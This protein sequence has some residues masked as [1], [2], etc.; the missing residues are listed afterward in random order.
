MAESFADIYKHASGLSRLI[1]KE[2]DNLVKILA[3]IE[4][5]NVIEYE[6]RQTIEG[7]ESLN[8]LDEFFSIKVQNLAIFLPS[9]LPLYSCVVFGIIP[10]FLADK[11]WI[12]PPVKLR[13]IFEKLEKLL[14]LDTFLNLSLFYDSRSAFIKNYASSAD[15]IVF[16]GSYENSLN[17]RKSCAQ[18]C[19]FIF[20]G[21]GHNPILVLENSN[22]DLAV[23]KIFN[24]KM[25]NNGQ[26]CAGPDQI[27]I[28]NS[29]LTLFLEKLIA[30]LNNLNSNCKLAV[31]DNLDRILSILVKYKSKIVY[32]GNV[33]IR[34]NTVQPSIIISSD[35]LNFEEF[36]APIFFITP[37]ESIEELFKVYFDTPEYKK[38]AMYVSVFGE[39]KELRFPKSIVLY[40]KIIHEVEKANLPYGGYGYGASSITSFG[41]TMARPILIPKEIFIHFTQNE[42]QEKKVKKYEIEKIINDYN[43]KLSQIFGENLVFSFFFGSLATNEALHEKSDIDVFLCVKTKDDFAVN[44]FVKYSITYQIEHNLVPDEKYPVEIFTENELLKMIDEMDTIRIDILGIKNNENIFDHVILGSILNAPKIGLC[45]NYSLINTLASKYSVVLEKWKFDILNIID[46]VKELSPNIQLPQTVSNVDLQKLRKL[47]NENDIDNIRLSD[48]TK[49]IFSSFTPNHA[50]NFNKSE[51]N[52]VEKVKCIHNFLIATMRPE[53]LFNQIY[54]FM[55]T[56]INNRN[57]CFFVFS[58]DPNPLTSGKFQEEIRKIMIEFPNL[59]EKI[60]F[61]DYEEQIKILSNIARNFSKYSG[62][63]SEDEIML[64]FKE[65]DKLCGIRSIQNKFIAIFYYTIGPESVR[66]PSIVHRLDDDVFCIE[67]ARDSNNNILISQKNDFFQKKEN[68]LLNKSKVI[69]GSNFTID[70]PSPLVDFLSASEFILGY[71]DQSTKLHTPEVVIGSEIMKISKYACLDVI[72]NLNNID[73]QPLTPSASLK[74]NE[75]MQKIPVYFDRIKTGISR[76]MINESSD[77]FHDTSLLNFFP[78]GCVSFWSNEFPALTPLYGNQDLLYLLFESFLFGKYLVFD[79]YMGHIKVSNTR[80]DLISDLMNSSYKHQTGLTFD[81][82][83]YFK[84]NFQDRLNE[85]SLHGKWK[86]YVL[87]RFSDTFINFMTQS[88][89]ETEHNIKETLVLLDLLNE[90]HWLN[91]PQFANSIKIIKDYFSQ[92]IHSMPSIKKNFSFSENH[93]ATKELIED[94][95]KKM[96]CFKNF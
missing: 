29:L 83:N 67:A 89:N 82:F 79:T 34:T 31:H 88:L 7:L 90:N 84:M 43:T 25:F 3:E 69:S 63:I 9:N 78:G 14:C 40:N 55:M 51:T 4:N 21:Q 96:K 85:E 37:Y 86:E 48:L 2:K 35:K 81:T 47:I 68:S 75:I 42:I 62:N 58:D 87:N 30:K 70:S 45:G 36:F 32:G 91:S 46:S 41:R 72:N 44:N 52:R 16:N 12:R 13:P 76:F 57:V 38:F 26:D 80:V 23:Q 93:G 22:I 33:D 94:Y 20:N 60:Y 56:D 65:K 11:T 77:S 53:L 24:V 71:L 59:K 74:Y 6:I 49:I 27:F 64:C 92:F 28:Q 10:S 61:F 50:K 17:V 8:V 15:V 5:Y 19:L 39:N 54:T 95:L 1:I 18:G 66:I 73:I